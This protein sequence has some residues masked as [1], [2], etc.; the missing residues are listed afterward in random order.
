MNQHKTTKGKALDFKAFPFLK[1]IYADTSPDI[2]LMFSA[3]TGKTE[4]VTCDAFALISMGISYQIVQPKDDL[5]VMFARTRIEPPIQMSK[6]YSTYCKQNGKMFEWTNPSGPKGLLKI[7][8][9][10]R[11]DE[12]IAFP[13]DAVG[14]DEVDKC[15]LANLSLLPDRML[16]SE[17]KLYRRSSTPTTVGNDAVPNIN[18]YYCQTD[19]RKYFLTCKHC[20]EVQHL[21]WL[22]NVVNEIRNPQ[23]GKLESFEL[24][25][26]DWNEDS[27]RDIYLMCSKCQ[28]PMN[29]LK[30][31]EWHPTSKIAKRLRKRGYNA[32][33][34]LSPRVELSELW[35]GSDGYLKSANNPVMM[36]RFFNSILGEPYLGSGTQVT[37]DMLDGCCQDYYCQPD[38]DTCK[39]PCSMGVD[40]GPEYLDVRISSYPH[41]NKGIRR[42]EYANKVRDFS[43]LN[44]LVNRF[45]VTCA[46]IDAEPE[47]RSALKFQELAMCKV[48]VCYTREIKGQT[49]MDLNVDRVKKGD[50]LSIDRTLF[51][52]SVMA[53]YQQGEVIL[54]KN[55]R[56]LS[57]GFWVYEMTNP[58]RVLEVDDRGNEKFVWTSGADHS[59]LAD[60]YDLIAMHLGYFSGVFNVVSG[61]KRPSIVLSDTKAEYDWISEH[62]A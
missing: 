56:F 28:T 27:T 14:I 5:R 45:N 1:A 32:G 18:W 54:P 48:Y 12:M 39:G 36:Q 43:E 16:N 34:L 42:M 31:G 2:T 23:T 40:V 33:K 11:A 26:T 60:V 38:T 37:E 8:F 7:A 15:D 61:E 30:E 47:T 24:Y 29:R 46:V 49:L 58:T 44:N 4:W 41:R 13:A 17:Y 35:L 6:F 59:F 51:M 62:T 3:Q 57:N 19:K 25:D 53:S 9:S 55:I 52:D 20:G 50:K 10:N 22:K 21:D